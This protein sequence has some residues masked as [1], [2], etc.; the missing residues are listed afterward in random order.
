MPLPRQAIE[1]AIELNGVEIAMNKAAFAWGRRAAVEPAAVAAIADRNRGGRRQADISPTLDSLI[2]RRVEFLTAYQDA[3]YAA[4]YAAL[5]ARVREAEARIAPGKAGL[6]EAV[7]V[8]LFKLMAIKDEYEVARLFTD[9]SFWRQLRRE[10]SGWDKLEFHLAPPLLAK[11]DPFTGRLQKKSY[12]PWMMRAFRLLASAKRLRGTRL[13]LFGRSA[14][15]R[16]ERQ[17]LA[18]YEATIETILKDLSAD[19]HERAVV[20]ALWPEGVRGFGH[21]KAPTI[22]RARAEAAA[23]QEIFLSA[24]PRVAEAAE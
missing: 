21:V 7:A 8:N 12:G 3:D 4:R 10:F 14:E 2:E 15:R 16:T 20:L 1:Q 22:E 17:L 19:R 6:G 9:G 23:R 11:R 13:D 24:A 5:V 18:D